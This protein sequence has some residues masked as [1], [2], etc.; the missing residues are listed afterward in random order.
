MPRNRITALRI[1]VAILLTAFT[2]AFIAPVRGYADQAPTAHHKNF[3]QRHPV[4][5]S[6]AAAALTH[7]ALKVAARN[8]KRH[9]QKLTWAERHPTLSAVGVGVVTHHMIKKSTH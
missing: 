3:V 2:A 5:T 7:H 1:V 6:I 8:R 4:V 9:H